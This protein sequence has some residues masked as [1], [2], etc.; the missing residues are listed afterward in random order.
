MTWPAPIEIRKPGNEQ[1][2]E[3]AA[4]A[5]D[6]PEQGA[7]P[8]RV[9]R[10]GRRLADALTRRRAGH[11]PRPV[12]G[13][14]R[15]RWPARRPGARHEHEDHPVGPGPRGIEPDGARDRGR[16]DP[17]EDGRDDVRHVLD[18]ELDGEQLVPMRAI[19][20]LGEERRLDDLRAPARRPTTER[21]ERR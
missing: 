9:R 3:P 19:A 4:V 20:V 17:A 2:G 8:A 14:E 7:R 21:R 12:V 18:R 5:D 15:R 13:Q 10:E 1:L 16:A 11:R 6:D